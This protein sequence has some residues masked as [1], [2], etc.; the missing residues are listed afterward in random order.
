MKPNGSGFEELINAV[1]R[2]LQRNRAP[3]MTG[4]NR[5]TLQEENRQEDRQRIRREAH[6]GRRDVLRSPGGSPADGRAQACPQL[7]L[8]ESPAVTTL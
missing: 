6:A 2:A 1:N 3:Y 4:A 5:G 8:G 7:L